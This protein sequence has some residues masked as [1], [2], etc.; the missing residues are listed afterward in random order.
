M[1]FNLI[2]KNLYLAL[3]KTQQIMYV[4]LYGTCDPEIRFMWV[5]KTDIHLF[6]FVA[7]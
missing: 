7:F 1:W 5:F 4:Y 3:L 2:L 6:V